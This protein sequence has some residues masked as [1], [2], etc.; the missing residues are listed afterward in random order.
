MTSATR[1]ARREVELSIGGMTC[2]SCANRIERK[3]NKVDGVTATVNYA[4][5]KARV[6]FPDSVAP[7]DLVQVVEA[8]GYTAELPADKPADDKP[9]ADPQR[10]RLIVSATLA[11]PVIL[12]SMIPLLQFPNWQWLALTLASPVVVWGALPFHRAAWA[13]LRHGAATMD[14]LISVCVLAAFGWSLY[15]L[16]WGDAGMTGMTMSFQLVPE[17]GASDWSPPSC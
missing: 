5:E 11:V 7:A 16:F 14:T 17:R 13:N 3:L 12:L 10:Q 6:S 1:L 9:E 8:A 15:A 4:T 2:A